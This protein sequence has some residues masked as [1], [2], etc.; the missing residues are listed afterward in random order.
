MISFFAELVPPAMD[1]EPRKM[2]GYPCLFVNGNLTL[3]LHADDLL[4]RLDEASRKE[5]L[6]QP[7]AHPFEP[8]PGRPMKEY[9]V[10]PPAL[11][12]DETAL[13]SWVERSLAYGRSLPPKVKKAKPKAS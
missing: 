13:S 5:F 8:M 4:L 7:G 10:A 11:L 9:V 3:G 2:F 1:I 12:Q 6:Q